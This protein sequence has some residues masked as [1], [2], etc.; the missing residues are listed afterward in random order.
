MP[1]K[2]AVTLT[3]ASTVIDIA[4]TLFGTSMGAIIANAINRYINPRLGYS[5]YNNYVFY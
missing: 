4:L 5:R 1:G 2:A 3:V